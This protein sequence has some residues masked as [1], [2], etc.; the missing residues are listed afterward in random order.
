MN[1]L[2]ENV[3]KYAEAKT[4][5]ALLNEI[6]AN[7]VP[8]T[9]KEYEQLKKSVFEATGANEDFQ[10][11]I[12]QIV[13]SNFPQFA[14]S[15][16]LAAE[17]LDGVSDSTENVSGKM[18][19]LAKELDS[20]VDKYQTVKN[21]QDEF[22]KSG[23]LTASTLSDIIDKY[24]EMEDAVSQYIAGLID[25]K[26]LLSQLSEHYKTDEENYKNTVLSKIQNS[27]KFAEILHSIESHHA[28]HLTSYVLHQLSKCRNEPES[29]TVHHGTFQHHNDAE[30][31]RSC[32]LWQRGC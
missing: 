24:P 31:L 5:E 27:E 26:T 29:I 8:K 25:E 6:W 21:A 2:T 14:T 10:Q 3:D 4:Q 16:E 28:A 11:K 12:N 20:M 22:K 13:A 32:D 30:L 19:G 23:N 7:G 18:E 15:A 9:T 1:D 17:S